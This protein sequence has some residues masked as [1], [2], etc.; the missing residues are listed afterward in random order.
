MEK[1]KI[2]TKQITF[3]SSTKIYTNFYIFRTD[4]DSQISFPLPPKITF[5]CNMHTGKVLLFLSTG[6]EKLS[7]QCNISSRAPWWDFRLSWLKKTKVFVFFFF[8]LSFALPAFPILSGN[9]SKLS[10]A[11]YPSFRVLMKY[12]FYLVFLESCEVK[13]YADAQ[14]CLQ[15]QWNIRSSAEGNHPSKIQGRKIE[16]SIS[17]SNTTQVKLWILAYYWLI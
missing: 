3:Q 15:A 2:Q 10:Q 12:L 1:G 16:M 4:T 14:R 17:A 7:I 8:G 13:C 5:L 11:S 9:L 6:N